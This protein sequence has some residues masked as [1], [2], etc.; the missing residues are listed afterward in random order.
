MHSDLQNGRKSEI[1]G[2]R[3]IEERSGFLLCHTLITAF[4]SRTILEKIGCEK[5][6]CGGIPISNRLSDSAR[7]ISSDGFVQWLN[8]SVLPL[9][10][11]SRSSPAIVV[12]EQ[13]VEIRSLKFKLRLNYVAS[14]RVGGFSTLSR[15]EKLL[16]NWL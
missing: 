14:A 16:P 6:G 2:P 3:K 10:R 12:F 7:L 15:S 1:F 9:V 8:A 5:L 4:G 13:D 11:L